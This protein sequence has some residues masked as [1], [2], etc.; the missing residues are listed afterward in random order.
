MG[1]DNLS[2]IGDLIRQSLQS[3]GIAERV[4]KQMAVA[5]WPEIVG[6]ILAQKQ[7]PSRSKKIF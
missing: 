4:E 2:K 3:A 7:R 5:H 1:V 6:D